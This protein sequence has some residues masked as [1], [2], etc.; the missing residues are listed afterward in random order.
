MR[1]LRGSVKSQ[2]K[3]WNANVSSYTSGWTVNAIIGVACCHM[4][5]NPWTLSTQPAKMLDATCQLQ[6][7]LADLQHT[8]SKWLSPTLPW[9]CC[10]TP[11]PCLHLISNFKIQ[12]YMPQSE[13]VWEEPFSSK[14]AV[15]NERQFPDIK[16]ISWRKRDHSMCKCKIIHLSVASHFLRQHLGH[17]NPTASHHLCS[18][19][20]P[21]LQ[22]YYHFNIKPRK[23]FLCLKQR[24]LW[25]L[26][27]TTIQC[28]FCVW[29]FAAGSATLV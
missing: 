26:P 1:E 4:S 28:L 5:L 22:V 10:E 7:C 20:L 29:Q 25:L 6:R 17:W 8:L 23:L 18:P 12:H 3:L 27:L 11:G 14:I 2:A 15:N 19:P 13:N 16:Y 24:P 9:R 21:L